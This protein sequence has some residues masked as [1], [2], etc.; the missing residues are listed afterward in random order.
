MESIWLLIWTG[1]PAH[2]FLGSAG[3]GGGAENFHGA[4]DGDSTVAKLPASTK[5]SRAFASGT[6][7]AAHLWACPFLCGGKGK[8][9]LSWTTEISDLP[10][11]GEQRTSHKRVLFKRPFAHKP[12]GG[13]VSQR[14]ILGGIKCEV[15]LSG[16]LCVASDFFFFLRT[17]RDPSSSFEYI[18]PGL[19]L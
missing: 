13:P 8:E 7:G 15:W 6:K 11:P 18:F 2:L 1:L 5:S 10:Y 12:N 9:A 19:D 17:I 16:G 14:H 3:L 4:Y